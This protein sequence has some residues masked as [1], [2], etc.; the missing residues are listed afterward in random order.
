MRL[1]QDWK[2]KQRGGGGYHIPLSEMSTPK[3]CVPYYTYTISTSVNVYYAT[4]SYHNEVI[5][6]LLRLLHIIKR[7]KWVV[8]DIVIV[9]D[10]RM[11]GFSGEVPTYT[12]TQIHAVRMC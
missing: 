9:K 2:L 11:L 12:F 5:P 1:P 10:V 3:Q 7:L 6:C 4:Y 8:I